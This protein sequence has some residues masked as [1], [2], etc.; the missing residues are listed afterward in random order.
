MKVTIPLQ[1]IKS[2]AFKIGDK[3]HILRLGRLDCK[4][5]QVEKYRY[6]SGTLLSLPIFWYPQTKYH[7]FWIE[8]DNIIGSYHF[9]QAKI[10]KI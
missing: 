10:E 2:R 8:F 6:E 4:C 9:E 3:V 7:S 5:A 1:K